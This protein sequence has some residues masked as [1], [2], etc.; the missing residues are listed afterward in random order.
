MSVRLNLAIAVLVALASTAHAT[1]AQELERAREQFRSGQFAEAIPGLNYL[2]YPSP[3]LSQEDDLLEAR[4]LLAVC[5][6]E[7]GDRE[8]AKL[9]FTTVL[10]EDLRYTLD[11]LLF[12]ESVVDYFD[13]LK[14]DARH[15]RPSATVR[16][17]SSVSS[18]GRGPRI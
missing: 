17:E 11:T 12:S 10:Q 1:P 14:R 8:T 9:E 4:V 15:S 18:K 6:F 13:E 7:A 2:L 16:S 5:A 3:R